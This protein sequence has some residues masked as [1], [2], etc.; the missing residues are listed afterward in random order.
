MV[1]RLKRK[2]Y[3]DRGLQR[4]LRG[5]LIEKYTILTGKERVDSQMF[6]QVATDSRGLRGQTLKH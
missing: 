1:E 4:R 6:F 2:T 3:K 5:D